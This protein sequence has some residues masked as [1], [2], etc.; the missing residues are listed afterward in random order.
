[1]AATLYALEAVEQTVNNWI[2]AGGE[3]STVEEGVL[4]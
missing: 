2:E 1:M 4:G 3:I